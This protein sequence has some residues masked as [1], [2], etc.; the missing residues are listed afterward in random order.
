LISG[1]RLLVNQLRL[2]LGDRD[3]PPMHARHAM[4]RRSGLVEKSVTST[5][6]YAALAAFLL[7]LLI[8]WVARKLGPPKL[9]AKRNKTHGLSS[10]AARAAAR[11]VEPGHA[12]PIKPIKFGKR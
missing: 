3:P 1:R 11:S 4:A 6:A 7:V 2:R 5:H 12:P 10:S 8:W 9:A